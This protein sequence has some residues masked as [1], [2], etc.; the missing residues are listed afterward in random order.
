MYTIALAYELRDTAFKVNAVCPGFTK[1][2]LNNHR[3]TGFVEDA[4]RQLV[5]HAVI[6]NDGPTGKYICE[7][8]YLKLKNV[9]GK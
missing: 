8:F 2:D 1:T 7:E 9:L 3:G 4:G 6:D 5:K